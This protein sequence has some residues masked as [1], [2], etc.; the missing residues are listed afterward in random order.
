MSTAGGRVVLSVTSHQRE[1]MQIAARGQ[2][3]PT[4]LY[5]A[6]RS[7]QRHEWLAGPVHAPKLTPKGWALLALLDPLAAPKER[8]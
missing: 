4:W 1:A 2:S 7:A 6:V 8:S 3:V 5:R